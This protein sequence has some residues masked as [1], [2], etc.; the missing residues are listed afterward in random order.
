MIPIQISNPENPFVAAPVDVLISLG[1]VALIYSI[2]ILFV[3]TFDDADIGPS[4]EASWA[5]KTIFASA[6]IFT[7]YGSTRNSPLL[8][9]LYLYTAILFV[10]VLPVLIT[11]RTAYRLAHLE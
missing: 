5:F 6:L 1:I 9:T 8:Q 11:A 7:I 3:G 10:V 4:I 2:T